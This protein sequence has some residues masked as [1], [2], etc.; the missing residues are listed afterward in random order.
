[1]KKTWTTRLAVALL[2][3]TMITSC[4]VG[5]TFAKYVTKA[6]GTDTA[7]VAKW[8]ILVTVEGNVFADKYA[9]EDV[10]YLEAGGEY[11]VVAFAEEGEEA[12]Q[13]VAPGT[14]SDQL[15]QTLVGTVFGTP[16]VAARYAMTGT[17]TDIV[18]PAGTYTDY[19]VY[20]FNE[21]NYEDGYTGTFT[22]EEDYSPIKWNLEIENSIGTKINVADALYEALPANL[23][24]AAEAYGLTPTGCSFFAAVEILKKVAGNEG[25]INI[26]GDAIG[27]IVSG[28][29]NFMLEVEDDGTFTLSYDFD[30]NTEMDYT[31]TLS[32]EWAFEQE[33]VELYDK[34][35]TYLGNIAAEVE[36]IVIPE[37][38]SIEIS[39]SL[40]ASA[41]Q[42][43]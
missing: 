10:D 28:G 5:S 16:E 12:D 13:V 3:L 11:S 39:A 9:A 18:L 36:G 31:F 38:A 24:D 21:E 19:T 25:Y 32:W 23:I 15:D 6:E 41:T 17:V 37:G 22:L 43:D 27:S 26:V 14:S 42:I 35:D 1:M 33:N 4:F 7:R 2:A 8:G 40:V 34:A 20:H 29:R 30:P